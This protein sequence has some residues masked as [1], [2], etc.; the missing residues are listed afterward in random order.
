MFV[1]IIPEDL[2]KYNLVFF[3]YLVYLISSLPVWKCRFN[4][5]KLTGV[6]SVKID[7][8][9]N[10]KTG[11]AGGNKLQQDVGPSLTDRSINNCS[12]L[13]CCIIWVIMSQQ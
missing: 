10:L 12:K 9:Q 3:M 8:L 11:A 4:R 2:K 5:S 1:C 13:L 6:N 7:G